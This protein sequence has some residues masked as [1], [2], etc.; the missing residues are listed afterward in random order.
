MKL[1]VLLPV[2]DGGGGEKTRRPRSMRM[3]MPLVPETTVWKKPP[4]PVMK[5]PQP[6]LG[7]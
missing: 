7:D 3:P 2:P 6:P 4:A 5:L 1:T